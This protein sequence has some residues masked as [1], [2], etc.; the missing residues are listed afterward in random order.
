MKYVSIFCLVLL[1]ASSCQ[2]STSTEE[3]PTEQVPKEERSKVVEEVPSTDEVTFLETAIGTIPVHSSFEG[4]TSIFNKN[5]DTTYVINFWATWCKP[6]VEELPYFEKI[7]A[8]YQ[9][10]KVQVV[11][12]SLDFKRQLETKL[13][14][15]LTKY[16]LK[17][18]VV[19]LTDSKYNNW[20]DKVDTDW[21]GAIPVTMIYNA[22]KRTFYSDQFSDFQELES[23]LKTFL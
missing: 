13:K 15:F 2:T 7:Q 10:E 23:A 5:N 20:I 9:E 21:G 11:L 12:I 14:D 4:I 18:K 6:C 19:V 17:S 16:Q 8:E 22:E 1:V 3:T